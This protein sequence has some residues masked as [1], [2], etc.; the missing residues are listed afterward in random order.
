VKEIA[1]II[2]ENWRYQ[3]QKNAGSAQRVQKKDLIGS[4]VVKY[5]K[6][7]GDYSTPDDKV[8]D[9][10]NYMVNLARINIRSQ[11]KKIT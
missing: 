3:P 7:M 10:I 9:K 6:T 11:L 5:R 2:S 4:L 1:S 8:R